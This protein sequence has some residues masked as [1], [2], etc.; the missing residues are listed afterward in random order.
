MKLS[1]L[2]VLGI[3]LML[4]ARVYAQAA[5]PTQTTPS[6]GIQGNSPPA[7]SPNDSA[8][9]ARAAAVVAA[10]SIINARV[11]AALDLDR[12]AEE[13]VLHRYVIYALMVL[14]AAFLGFLIWDFLRGREIWVE[15]HWGGFGGGVSGFRISRPLAL[16]TLLLIASGLLMALIVVPKS[17]DNGKESTS[18]KPEST[19]KPTNGGAGAPAANGATSATK[20]LDGH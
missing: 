18:A 1:R 11:K 14:V 15:S 3:A 16:V 7:S 19:A 8:T 6:R 9:R 10:D 2:V 20:G 5:P 13:R 17:P 4:D 12:N